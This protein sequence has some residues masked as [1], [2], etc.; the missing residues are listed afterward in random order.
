MF[1]VER[2]FVVCVYWV[3]HVTYV[4]V[5][6]SYQLYLCIKSLWSR[7]KI[8]PQFFFLDILGESWTSITVFRIR[9]RFFLCAKEV[10]S[11]ESLFTTR[12][13]ELT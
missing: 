10:R 4:K 13:I 2:L 8:S 6:T 3:Y 9:P 12:S 1:R 5:H 11:R 7:I